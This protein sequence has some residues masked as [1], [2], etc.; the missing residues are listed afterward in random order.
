MYHWSGTHK[1]LFL[2]IN[3]HP[4]SSNTRKMVWFED[5]CQNLKIS[6]IFRLLSQDSAVYLSIIRRCWCWENWIELSL[7][8]TLGWAE[9]YGERLP[10]GSS[11]SS[12]ISWRKNN[13]YILKFELF[14]S[15][16][17]LKDAP[18]RISWWNKRISQMQYIVLLI[19]DDGEKFI[20]FPH[21]HIVY[22]RFGSDKVYFHMRNISFI[23]QIAT[24]SNRLDIYIWD[25]HARHTEAQH[26]TLSFSAA[27]SVLSSSPIRPS[28]PHKHDRRRYCSEMMFSFSL[29]WSL[30]CIVKEG[31]VSGV[32]WSMTVVYE[33]LRMHFECN[34]K[35]F[36]MKI[37]KIEN[38]I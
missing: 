14:P 11:S 26:P 38:E 19:D 8:W 22:V 5:K 27:V 16:F 21:I 25:P 35:H 10:K 18:S 15:L 4:S 9:C 33:K 34:H 36:G 13:P 3:T 28:L 2:M 31:V 24:M 7:D 23:I 37:W 17:V 32:C 12:S 6:F 30:Y 1:N 29:K 20:L